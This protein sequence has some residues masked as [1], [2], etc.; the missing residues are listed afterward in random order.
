MQ[1]RNVIKG[2]VTYISDL[3]QIRRTTKPDLFKKSLDIITQDQQKIF[4]EVRNTGIK[5]LDRE[6]IK[7]GSYVE[8]EF[9]FEGSE[10]DGRKYNNVV[11]RNIKLL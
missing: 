6:G 9:L 1:E 8:V 4:V 7:V 5:E 11:A 2:F 10:K 3:I